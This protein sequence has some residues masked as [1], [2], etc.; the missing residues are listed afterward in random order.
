MVV[1]CVCV[2]VLVPD[3]AVGSVKWSSFVVGSHTVNTQL[4]VMRT[5]QW[6]AGNNAVRP[7]VRVTCLFSYGS[8]PCTCVLL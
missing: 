1:C 6:S 3:V 2:P 8:G 7:R 5:V 4:F